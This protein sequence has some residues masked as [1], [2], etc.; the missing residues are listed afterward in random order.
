MNWKILASAAVLALGVTTNAYAGETT[1]TI[2]EINA[3]ALS[4]TLDDGST[5]DFNNPE[6]R[7]ETA[8]DLSTYKAGDK[9][10]IVWED[11]QGKRVGM[12][13]SSQN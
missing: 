9:V 1:G 8:C 13:I 3:T 11:M 6:C 4:V 10:L 7:A 2:T 5:Y 12:D